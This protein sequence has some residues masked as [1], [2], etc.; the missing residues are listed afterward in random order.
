MNV[1]LLGVGMQGKAALRDLARSEGVERVVA[2]DGN[3]EMLRAHVEE[4][5]YGEKVRCQRLQAG[6]RESLDRLFAEGPDV[7]ID[8]LPPAFIGAVGRA[9]VRHGV[10]LVNT[11]Y[12]TAELGELAPRAEEEGVSLLPEL[13]MDPGIDLVLLGE[14]TRGFERVREI[15]TYGSGI[16][17]PEDADNPVRYKVSW[18]FEGVLR[19]YDRPAR[20]VERGRAVEIPA[21]EIFRPEHGHDLEVEGIGRLEAYPNGDVL[22]LVHLLGLNRSHLARAGRYTL[23]YPGH[24]AFWGTLAELGLLDDEPV[25]VDG[26]RVDK[27]SFLAAALEPRLR[28]DE[29]ERDVGI[30]RVEVAGL[31]KGEPTVCTFQ[32]V[33]RRDLETGLTAMSRLVGFS[34]SVGAQMIARGQID[35]PGLLSPLR[36]VPYR[37]FVRALEERGI[38]VTSWIDR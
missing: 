26:A 11:M 2:A 1:L 19:S 3:E 14:A 9:A 20:V 24:R 30:I 23:R 7:A 21:R 37:P 34:A 5:G 27:K 29:G 8:L 17:V 16:P 35:R 36:D 28:Y 32:V 10:H 25:F 31:R 18:T 4:M 33:D 22:D 38:T 6:R 12:T 15:L 13:G